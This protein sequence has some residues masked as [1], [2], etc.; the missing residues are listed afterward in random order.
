MNHLGTVKID[1]D[2]LILRKFNMEDSSAMFSNWA[3]DEN[4]TKFLTWKPV[5]S[6]DIA[7]DILT[8]WVDSYSD[9]KFYQW[10]IVLKENQLE[11]I[12]TINVVHMNEE[13]N[14]VHVGYCIG[15][16]WW[17]MGITTEAFNGIIPFLIEEVGV[18]RIESRHDP[19][20]E[21]SGKVMI[22]CGLKFEGTLRNADINNQGICDA[23]MYSLLKDEYYTKK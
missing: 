11:P 23:C 15:K 8:Q 12:G 21:N 20:N 16:K 5:K 9:P 3:N 10:A 13:I 17:H 6:I 7:K 2:R 4:V 19:R 1:T 18:K 14:M 22:K